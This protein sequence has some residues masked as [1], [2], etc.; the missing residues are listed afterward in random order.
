[1]VRRLLLTALLTLLAVAPPAAAEE[2]PAPSGIPAGPGMGSCLPSDL[3]CAHEEASA[4]CDPLSMACPVEAD[5]LSVDSA[6]VEST[7]SACQA[8]D[9]NMPGTGQPVILDPDGCIRS[10]IR[11][12]LG[13]PPGATAQVETAAPAFVDPFAWP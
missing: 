11:R 5:A 1:M 2:D 6:H 7:E 13:W 12:T 8:V 3:A 10:F 4:M 9:M